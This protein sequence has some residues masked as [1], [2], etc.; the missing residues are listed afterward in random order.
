MWVVV[1]HFLL[2]VVPQLTFGFERSMFFFDVGSNVFLWWRGHAFFFL[3]NLHYHF[4]NFLKAVALFWW[5]T[6][7]FFFFQ[8]HEAL[9]LFI[10]ESVILF[11]KNIFLVVNIYFWQKKISC[12]F[13]WN[14]M[15]LT[16]PFK[17]WWWQ[18]IK[19]C[20]LDMLIFVQV[21][22]TIDKNLVSL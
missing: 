6:L 13:C 8:D 3:P 12:E 21:C 4:F 1:Q 10:F 16:L 18:G 14:K 11:F 20:Q 15:C 17:F 9:F 22:R 7:S 2:Y 5:S 19:N